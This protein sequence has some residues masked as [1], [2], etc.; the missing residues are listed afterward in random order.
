[1]REFRFAMN[2][3]SDEF[4]LEINRLLG[5]EPGEKIAEK[6]KPGR[7]TGTGDGWDFFR[8]HKKG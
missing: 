8:A 2:A 3:D 7:E 1:M 4:R 6:E 5:L